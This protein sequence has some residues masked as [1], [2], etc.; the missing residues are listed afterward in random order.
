MPVTI[1]NYLK[2]IKLKEQKL[3]NQNNWLY[4]RISESYAEE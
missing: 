1:R 2:P 4:K 3:R